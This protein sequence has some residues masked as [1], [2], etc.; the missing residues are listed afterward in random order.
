[1]SPWRTEDP[2]FLQTAEVRRSDGGWGPTINGNLV[3]RYTS[4]TIVL[5]R[6]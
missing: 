4:R 6:L 3:G 5:P 1:M 2:T